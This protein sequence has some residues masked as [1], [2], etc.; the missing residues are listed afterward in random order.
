MEGL[1]FILFILW[2]FGIFNFNKSRSRGITRS[3]PP[4]N[5]SSSG[6]RKDVKRE[7]RDDFKWKNWMN[8]T[9]AER[10]LSREKI[11]DEMRG[12]VR[13]ASPKD[14]AKWLSGY[15]KKG[16][17]IRYE[18]TRTLDSDY[19]VATGDFELPS[20]LCGANSVNLIVPE[21]I[22]VTYSDRGHC[23][24]MWMDGYEFE[25][26][27]AESFTDPQIKNVAREYG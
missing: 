21:G 11:T 2:I 15:L 1:L 14:Y 7:L 10:H 12:N 16:G 27:G 13:P 9:G 24:I 5:E 25:G 17:E 20:R 23:R 8:K 6:S 19:F 18:R 22:D 26:S 3:N 4:S